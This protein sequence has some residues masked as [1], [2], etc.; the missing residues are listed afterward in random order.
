VVGPT[1]AA[2][3]ISLALAAAG[4]LP[5]AVA[6]R[7]APAQ[8]PVRS[9]GPR[10]VAALRAGLYIDTAQ[11]WLVVRP[12]LRVARL[13]AMVDSVVVDG[14]VESTGGGSQRLGRLLARLEAGNV[15]L[16]L[17]GLAAG[18]VLVALAVAVGA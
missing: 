12:T 5:V 18:A 14:A 16:Y 15:Q 8:D 9:L 3:A 1:L 6:W 17:T 2:T 11:D 7:R 10:T 13:V 4:A